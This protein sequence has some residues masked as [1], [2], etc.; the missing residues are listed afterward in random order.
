M[1]AE[2]L[3]L[4]TQLLLKEGRTQEAAI[5]SE[6]IEILAREFSSDGTLQTSHVLARAQVL[7]ATGDARR[8][9]QI[10]SLT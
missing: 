2:S 4:R 5:C 1:M 6:R 3:R 10:L 7:V 9:L 8:G